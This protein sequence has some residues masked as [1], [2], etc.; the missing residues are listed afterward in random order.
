MIGDNHTKVIFGAF[1]IMMAPLI[2]LT[3]YQSNTISQNDQYI[4]EYVNTKINDVEKEGY[5][6]D[7]IRNDIKT[8]LFNET[9]YSEIDVSGTNEKAESGETVY[10]EVEAK[11]YNRIGTV[12]ERHQY[13]KES[14][15]N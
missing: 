5:L 6:T 8:E 13:I 9:I 7:S 4:E 14:V 3:L 1:I 10:I 2:G 15:A 11:A 12:A